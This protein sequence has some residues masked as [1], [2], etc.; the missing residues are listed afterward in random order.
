MKAAAQRW[1]FASLFLAVLFLPA[2][3]HAFDF[4]RFVVFGASLADSGNAFALTGQAI[5]APYSELDDFLIPPAPYAEG[6]NRFSNGPTWIEHLARRLDKSPS[7]EPA[8]ADDGGRAANYAVGGA[9]AREDGVNRNLPAQVATF[10][11]DVK[12][13]APADALYVIDMGANDV[14]DALLAGSEADIQLILG[15]ALGSI[16]AQLGN[17][18]GA[19]A[20][21]F[22]ILNVPDLGVLPSI[23]ILDSFFP[24]A[25]AFAGTLSQVF[26]G[27]LDS[28]VAAF[29]ALPEVEIARLNVYGKVNEI[30]ARPADFRLSETV[31][32]CLTPDVAPFTCKKPGRYLFWDG[33]HPTTAVHEIFAEEAADVLRAERR[34]SRLVNARER[35]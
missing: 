5:K 28:L 21:K 33:V 24:G 34:P 2:G 18:Y 15:D 30:I 25:A 26:N 8:F 27:N 32:P 23:R 11:D 19:G 4:K 31:A 16:G 10:L 20:R 9:R 12:Y 14:R 22:L 17:L 1:I 35:R 6:G 13:K 7:V 29:G 3:A